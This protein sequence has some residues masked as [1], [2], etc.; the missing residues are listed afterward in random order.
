MDK[1]FTDI[2]ELSQSKRVKITDSNVM[3]QTE[4]SE[5]ITGTQLSLDLSK[6]GD[7]D[8]NDPEGRREKR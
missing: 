2:F 7:E 1:S 5:S 4:K 3:T 8:T 6:A